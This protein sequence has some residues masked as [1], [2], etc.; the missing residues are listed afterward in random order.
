MPTYILKQKMV[1]IGTDF[2]IMDRNGNKVYFVDGYGFSIGK[3][4]S[5]QSK[6]GTELVKIKQVLGSF[7]PK[8]KIKKGSKVLAVVKKKP[9]T[10]RDC[11]LVDVPGPNDYHVVG[12][13]TEHEYVFKKNGI[14]VAEVS[15]KLFKATDTYSV[16]ITGNSDPVIILS[17][18]VII[19]TI[20]HNKNSKHHR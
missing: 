4:F 10:M 15:R 14:V 9:F 8:Y 16:D 1:S 5:F 6:S 3:K 11:F 7:S 13:F 19:D 18:A 17:S 20:C 12:R 2:N